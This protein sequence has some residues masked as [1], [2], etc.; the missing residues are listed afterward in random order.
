MNL[1]DARLSSSRSNRKPGRRAKPSQRG[2]V[3]HPTS[4]RPDGGTTGRHQRQVLGDKIKRER[5]RS[6]N[7]EESPPS[8]GQDTC[9][10]EVEV[11]LAHLE[12]H[13]QCPL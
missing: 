3:N 2:L 11:I 7:E 13:Y 8:K 6:G 12:E 5:T 9:N 4:R 1:L 10:P